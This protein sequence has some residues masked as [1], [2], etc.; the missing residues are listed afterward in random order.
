MKVLF[1]R[2]VVLEEHFYSLPGDVPEMDRR[3]EVIRYVSAALVI[4]DIELLQGSSRRSKENC[5][6]YPKTPNQNKPPTLSKL[7]V[8]F[9]GS[10][11]TYGRSSS[12]TRFVRDTCT[13]VD[14]H[15]T[16]RRHNNR[17][18]TGKGVKQ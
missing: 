8:K 11:K 13:V 7:I 6:F 3:N 10:S 18:S 15:T 1:S 9:L 17:R 16:N 2:I 4:L 12:I 14:V 5:R